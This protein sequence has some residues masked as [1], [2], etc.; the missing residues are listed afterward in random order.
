MRWRQ[1]KKKMPPYVSCFKIDGTPNTNSLPHSYAQREGRFFLVRSTVAPILSVRPFLS[2]SKKQ[3]QH[4][5]QE[6]DTYCGCPARIPLASVRCVCFIISLSSVWCQP[7]TNHGIDRSTS[8]RSDHS[9]SNNNGNSAGRK[10]CG[11]STV[12]WIALEALR[13]QD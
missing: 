1:T 12:L 6:E 5:S 8:N 7:D 9:C 13:D 11:S 4:E 2:S 3:W 10:D